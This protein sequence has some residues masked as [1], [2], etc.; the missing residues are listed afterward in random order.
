VK[1]AFYVMAWL[2]FGAA[3]YNL[4]VI[5]EYGKTE[6]LLWFVVSMMIGF[7]ML[8]NARSYK[9]ERSE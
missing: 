2:N 8:S 7:W 6:L 9:R 5:F 1:F 4:Y 3:S